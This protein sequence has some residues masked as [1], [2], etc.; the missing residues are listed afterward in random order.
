[1][2]MDD[3]VRED[4]KKNLQEWMQISQEIRKMKESHRKE[5]KKRET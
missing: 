2:E 5:N 4:N 3:R 1:M